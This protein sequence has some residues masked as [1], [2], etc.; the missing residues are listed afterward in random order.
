MFPHLGKILT[1]H[2]TSFETGFGKGKPLRVGKEFYITPLPSLPP[3][4]ELCPF[5]NTLKKHTHTK[6]F[7]TEAIA[8]V[9]IKVFANSLKP[10]PHPLDALLSQY[11]RPSNLNISPK[12][13][14]TQYMLSTAIQVPLSWQSCCQNLSKL[15]I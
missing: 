6:I 14:L 4:K 12:W 11:M 3:H 7:F 8:E 15:Y 2:F 1:Q 9:N 13:V 5:F 10:K